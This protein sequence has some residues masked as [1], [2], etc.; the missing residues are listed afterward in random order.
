MNQLDSDLWDAIHKKDLNAAQNLLDQ[1]A[2]LESKDVKGR[3]MLRCYGTDSSY[4]K[5]NEWLMS[6]GADINSKDNYGDTALHEV[7]K[8]A[9][10]KTFDWLMSQNIDVNVMNDQGSTPLIAACAVN[11]LEIIEELLEKGADPNKVSKWGNSPLF[12]ATGRGQFEMVKILLEHGADP[13]F[14]DKDGK[15]VIHEA[16]PIEFS[17]GVEKDFKSQ[18]YAIIN[19]LLDEH[20]DKIDLNK[21]TKFGT[22][23]L[24]NAV[25]NETL[26]YKMI[27]K[28]TS[29][30]VQ[31]DTHGGMTPLHIACLKGNFPLIELILNNGF[32]FSVKDNAGSTATIY[33]V[34]YIMRSLLENKN[35]IKELLEPIE[36]EI[37]QAM[38]DPSVSDEEK[39]EMKNDFENF[40]NDL[41][42]QQ[43][44][45][46][47]EIK[48][49]FLVILQKFI[50]NGLDQ[51]AL[52]DE[53][54]GLHI[55]HLPVLV[56]DS[57]LAQK[58]LD[59]GF[60]IDPP[61]AIHKKMSEYN[62][63]VDSDINTFKEEINKIMP[64][65]LILAVKKLNA[66]FVDFFIQKGANVNAVDFTGNNALL[67]LTSTDEDKKID[68]AI[69]VMH[70]QAKGMSNQDARVYFKQIEKQT[71]ELK[72]EV[73]NKKIS[74]LDKLIDS[75]I[76]IN[77]E[78]ENEATA[79]MIAANRNLTDL[80]GLLA[81]R[82]NADLLYKNENEDT[83]LSVALTSGNSLLFREM[84][85]II[86]EQGR[87][88]ETKDVVTQSILTAPEEFNEKT[89]FLKSLASVGN[90]PLWI[91][92]TDGAIPLIAA[93]ENDD[94]DIVKVLIESGA[95]VNIKDENGNTPLI[96]AVF[97][98]DKQ[99][100]LLLRSAGADV[101]EKN[102]KGISPIALSRS[103]DYAEVRTAM[104]TVSPNILEDR[105]L[106]FGMDPLLSIEDF[107]E[108]IP[109]RSKS[110]LSM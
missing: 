12:T 91:N 76:R 106:S 65:P 82:Y 68:M 45:S 33:L 92:N 30:N 39:E 29:S 35:K 73:L 80:V 74:V 97:N 54:K 67:Y 93:I 49:N 69:N 50:D 96:Y 19:L 5:A 42:E 7:I 18:I 44:E 79:L 8:V 90:D 37:S 83:A 100:V 55:M 40:K 38:A 103:S 23:I 58:L 110:K 63:K 25:D 105:S 98:K 52:Y 27:E 32:D 21:K 99:S 77:H 36:N 24:S 60:P 26:M 101:N 51:N 22:S 34:D 17:M 84:V 14:I 66:D 1:G 75:G 10:M 70:N 102:D 28:G 41:E 20:V 108:N 104:N 4:E 9:D 13:G 85:E 48:E 53:K 94:H 56:N 57:E 87:F 64:S 59:M 2:D 72:K 11:K 62:H 86:R 43:K 3:S 81:I 89:K 47:K 71:Q 61:S 109:T 78:N 107:W 88:E 31:F 95:N 46:V 16:R 6:K 15:N